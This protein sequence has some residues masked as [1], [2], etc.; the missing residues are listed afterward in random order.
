MAEQTRLE[1][2]S[3]TRLLLS[4]MVDLAEIPA[5]V[6]RGLNLVRVEHMDEV[7]GA[8]LALADPAAFLQS[9]D[10]EVEDIHEIS[11]PP[12]ERPVEVPSQAGIN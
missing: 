3:P 1:I 4:E 7:L 5:N 11:P 12:A 10:H 9:G 2:V 6:K 8:A